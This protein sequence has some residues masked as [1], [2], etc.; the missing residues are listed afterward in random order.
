MQPLRIT[1]NQACE[2]LSISRD[3]LRNL[4]I[5][6]KSFPRPIKCGNTRQAP[7]YF[8][9]IELNNWHEKQKNNN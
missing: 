4:I 3:N 2:I 1:F 6:D 9:Y 5:R 7:V 8:D